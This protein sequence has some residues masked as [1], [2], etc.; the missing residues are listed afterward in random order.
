MYNTR[1]YLFFLVS[2]QILSNVSGSRG[3]TYLL[4]LFTKFRPY[5][6]TLDCL[7]NLYRMLKKGAKWAGLKKIEAGEEARL[8]GLDPTDESDAFEHMF[9]TLSGPLKLLQVLI[10]LIFKVKFVYV[11]Y[12]YKH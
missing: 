9:K 5:A 1:A 6:W 11:F 7:A 4:E 2:G 12:L 3:P 8:A 10:A